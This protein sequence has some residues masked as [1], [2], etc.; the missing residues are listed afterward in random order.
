MVPPCKVFFQAVY[1]RVSEAA[2]MVEELAL[3][4]GHKDIGEEAK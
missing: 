2:A 4:N 3:G 1:D